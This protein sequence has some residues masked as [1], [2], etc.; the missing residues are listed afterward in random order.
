M[1]VYIPEGQKG[2]IAWNLNHV[3]IG[4]LVRENML[5]RVG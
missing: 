3:E 1:A 5:S 2:L 4:T